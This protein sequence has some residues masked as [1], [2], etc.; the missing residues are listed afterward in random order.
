MKQ[1]FKVV[2]FSLISIF[3][4]SCASTNKT[5]TIQI[6]PP[7]SSSPSIKQVALF[8]DGT[9]NDR[10]SRTN[11]STLSEIVK[12]QNRDNLYIF[13][14]EGVG[15]EGQF[16]GAGTGLGIDKDVAEAYAFL[17][18]YYSPDSKLYIFGF[19]RGA[20]TSRI[21]AGMIYS[22]GIYDL[23]SF[24]KK[25]RIK[26]AKDL[27]E[28]YKGKNKDIINIR[29]AGR[30]IIKEWRIKTLAKN[31]TIN[32]QSDYDVSIEVLG[33]WDTVEALGIVPTL[34]ALEGK[35]LGT[36][37]PQ[38]I[39]NPNGRYIDQI[40]NI[41]NVY[42]SLSLDDNRA[43]IFTPIIISSEF[44]IQ[45]CKRDAQFI[46]NVEE[47]WFSGAHADIGGGYQKNENNDKGDDTDR[48]LSISG[49]SLNWMMS[50]IKQSAPE[51]IPKN[52]EVFENSLGYIH[53]AQNGSS[54]YKRISRNHILTDYTRHSMYAKLKIHE[55]VFQRLSL[56]ASARKDIGF[57]SG[58]YMLDAFKECFDVTEDEEYIFKKCA[59]IEVVK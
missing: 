52:A 9:Q 5:Y 24:V 32:V 15:T 43:N 49:V 27:Y 54:M 28:A 56:K 17:S 33:L 4:M 38:N 7:L 46:T 58:W 29:E 42:Q 22:I 34:E 36:K 47:V 25:E 2:Y 44:V 14:N 41:K 45:K 18:E 12:H 8:L 13:Y 23:T 20:Y 21:L 26:I 53:D 48:D 30:N 35:I 37:D 40:C 39:I 10:D 51:L 3:L 1:L 59:L 50:R 55:S 11:V 31:K 57:D 6:H 16:V 19:S